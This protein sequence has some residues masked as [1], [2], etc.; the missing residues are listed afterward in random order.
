MNAAWKRRIAVLLIAA[1]KNAGLHSRLAL[2]CR[3]P[4]DPEALKQRIDRIETAR[5]DASA[6][7]LYEC[8][9][10]LNVSVEALLNP[11]SRRR[12]LHT[13]AHRL[14]DDEVPRALAWLIRHVSKQRES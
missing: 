8:A 5:S 10:R 6:A 7:F 3:L 14:P 1:R 9:Q 11:D 2:A 4:G 13:L 12:Q